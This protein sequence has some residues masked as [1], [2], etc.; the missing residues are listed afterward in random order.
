MR[1]MNTVRR[2]SGRALCLAAVLASLVFYSQGASAQW[3]GWGGPNRDF[4]VEASG[5]SNSWPAD[6]PKQLWSRKLGGGY[7]GIA[8]DSGVLFTMYRD[9]D[10]E[11]TIALD[12]AS[13][14]TIWEQ[15]F[16]VAIPEG[17]TKRFGEGPRSTPL[18]HGDRLYTLGVAGKVTCFT[19][20]DGKVLWS[21]DLI[22]D[23]GAKSP[24]FGFA[25]S[26]TVYDNLLIVAAGGKGAGIVAF[27]LTSGKVEW[28][29]FDY[30]EDREA[31]GSIYSSPVIINVDGEDQ[32]VLLTGIDIIGFDPKT[33][34][35][36]WK[37]PHENQYKTNI[38]TPVWGDGNLLYVTSGG[39]AGSRA[40]HLTRLGDKTNV[41]EVWASKNMAIGQ[42]NVIRVGDHVF[43]SGGRSSS[44]FLTSA[45]VK[46]GEIG[47][48]ERGFAK[49]MIL[50]ADGKFIV[51]DENGKL[52]IVETD[53]KTMKVLAEKQVL[54]KPAWTIPTL[55]GKT[56]YLRD[57]EV[58][59]AIDLG[60]HA[61]K[62]A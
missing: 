1:K 3:P 56:L 2:F 50:H 37:H 4:R 19:K 59:I 13:G 62:G 40:L 16:T 45:N 14:K 26:P 31:T 48:K 39:E 11:V 35:L 29:N 32:G 18:I 22:K 52:G 17:M 24:G 53:G 23:S 54:K 34:A 43:G 6:G 9:D 58:M 30:G 10:K 41:E 28:K 25:A 38:S 61:S 42:G 20:G 8:A 44:A 21:H 51:L 49:S 36:K 60:A 27:D 47:I 55:V 46:T 12:A 5:L 7:S 33:G 15:K 57:K